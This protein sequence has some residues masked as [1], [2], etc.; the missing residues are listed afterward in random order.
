MRMVGSRHTKLRLRMWLREQ[1]PEVP[2]LFGE[3]AQLAETRCFDLRSRQ[4][5]FVPQVDCCLAGF[6]C[7]SRAKNNI[8][9]AQ[10]KGCVAAGTS[11]TGESFT[12][13]TKYLV[14]KRPKL[15]VL[16]N[17]EGLAEGDKG[18]DEDTSD[19]SFVVNKLEE[20]G[21]A[22]AY[23]AVNAADY[24]SPQLRARL[25]FIG[26]YGKDQR[27]KLDIVRGILS[28]VKLPKCSVDVSKFL[29][30]GEELRNLQE[31]CLLHAKHHAGNAKKDCNYET[32]HGDIF[33]QQ[34]WPW[35][36]PDAVFEKECGNGMT[37]L[38]QRAKEVIYILHLLHPMPPTSQA[39][40]LT[41]TI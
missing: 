17:V 22:A 37:Y 10:N 14:A 31:D 9:R 5:V 11:D 7:K 36:L 1:F 41:R 38:P 34:G 13:V 8:H 26:F 28:E 24:G 20:I 32:E 23:F 16:E 40:L 30:D 33:L 6:I 18:S 2:H 15:V 25:Y 4:H 27:Q 12:F 35:P 19:A 39:R 21:Y 3:A 29:L